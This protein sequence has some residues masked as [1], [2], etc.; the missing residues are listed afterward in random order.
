[1]NTNDEGL[2][3]AQRV[4]P[5]E[6]RLSW[7]WLAMIGAVLLYAALD[8]WVVRQVTLVLERELENWILI[9]LAMM[10]GLHVLVVFLLRQMI[11]ALSKFSYVNYCIIRWALMEAVAVYG[12]VLGF[13]G[14]DFGITSIF[15]AAAV[16]LLAS[17][18]PGPHDRAVFVAQ[19]R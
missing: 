1:M 2:E 15:H 6:S 19:F 7:I 18:R 17:A 5:A 16:L 12:L 14:V 10:A 3:R 4:N 11:A 9:F 8:A 13:L